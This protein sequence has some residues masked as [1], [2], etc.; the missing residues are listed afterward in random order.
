MGHFLATRPVVCLLAFAFVLRAGMAVAVQEFLDRRPQRQFVIAGDAQGYWLLGQ[1]IA[2]GEPYAVYNPPRY[3]LRMPGFPLLLSLPIALFQGSFLATRLCLAGVGTAAC[4]LVY[5]L[6]R[7]LVDHRI[8]LSAG[9]FTAVSP[10]MVGFSV[11]I[12]SETAFAVGILG[13]LWAMTCLLREVAEGNPLP[14]LCGWALA[15][16]G[17]VAVATFMRPSWLPMALMFSAWL[18]FRGRFRRESLI[19][20]AVLAGSVFLLLMPWAARNHQRTGHWVFTTLWSGPSL[21][22]GLNPHATGESDMTFFDQDNLLSSMSEYEVNRH[23]WRAGLDYAREHPGRALQLALVKLWRFWKPWPSAA[24]A[25]GWAS[26]IVIA[27]FS[28]LLFAACLAGAWLYRR[29]FVLLALTVGPVLFFSVLHAIFVGSLRYR[30]PAEYP[31]AVLAAA[32]FRHREATAKSPNTAYNK[33]G[34]TRP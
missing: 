29:N 4:G 22:D 8:G 33:P 9:W 1:A 30:L 3:V 7:E 15:T 20:A 17:F 23:Y 19:T 27:A 12:L 14:R 6:G 21:Y 5:L 32:G 28:L 31:L 16:G 13:S 25:G 34:E 10:A 26:K 11:M 2:H 24:E 18:L